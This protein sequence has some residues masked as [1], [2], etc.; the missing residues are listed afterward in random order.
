MAA[1]RSIAVSFLFTHSIQGF[2]KIWTFLLISVRNLMN[3]RA[4]QLLK[5]ET[6]IQRPS[7]IA[8][9]KY[10]YQMQKCAI[11]RMIV[12]EVRMSQTAR[13][14]WI[15]AN[16]RMEAANIYVRMVKTE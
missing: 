4:L 8:A 5:K 11:K 7:S 15:S 13:V 3:E 12:A 16:M 2:K 14:W 6:V 1:M 9:I 10:A